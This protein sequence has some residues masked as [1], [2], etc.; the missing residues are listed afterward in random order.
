MRV[1]S[2]EVAQVF[3][4]AKEIGSVVDLR[5]NV[6]DLTIYMNAKHNN[7]NFNLKEPDIG[8]TTIYVLG[9][10]RQR[11]IDTRGNYVLIGQ[12]GILPGVICL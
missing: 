1:L 7:P 10:Y 3:S 2:I 11:G 5:K 12:I 8:R 4:L 6:T 9:F